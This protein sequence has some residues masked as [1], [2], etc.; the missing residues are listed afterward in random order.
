MYL[1][2]IKTK[3]LILIFFIFLISCTDN[4]ND[5]KFVMGNKIYN[6]YCKSCHMDGGKGL[7]LFSKNYEIHDILTAVS[8]GIGT[9]PSFRDILSQQEM[10]AVAYFINRK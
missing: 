8:N 7:N 4:S 6:N 5:Q 2:K 3:Y 10:D 9:M 1:K